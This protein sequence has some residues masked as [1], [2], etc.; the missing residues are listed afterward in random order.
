MHL[1]SS[2]I[3]DLDDDEEDLDDVD[4]Q[5]SRININQ[6]ENLGIVSEVIYNG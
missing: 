4:G 6:M 1:F 3:P 2:G 5:D